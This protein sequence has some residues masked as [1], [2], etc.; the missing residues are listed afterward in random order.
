MSPF[1]KRLIATRC[2]IPEMKEMNRV[3]RAKVEKSETFQLSKI[4]AIKLQVEQTE[5]RLLMLA[6]AVTDG[7]FDREIYLLKK[8]C[9]IEGRQSL[10][11]S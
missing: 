8:N 6:D 10:T 11:A 1:K 9:L 3:L 4:Q 7:I 2:K 5:E